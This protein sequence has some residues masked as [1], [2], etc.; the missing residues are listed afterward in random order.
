MT[1]IQKMHF[2]AVLALCLIPLTG[3]TQFQSVHVAGPATKLSSVT[4]FPS[5]NEQ[6]MKLRMTGDEMVPLPGMLFSVKQM[7]IEKFNVDGK[8]EAVV[9]APECTYAQLD[10]LASSSGHLDAKI[11]DRIH[12][13]GDGFLY[14]QSDNSLVISNNVYTVIKAGTRTLP[15]P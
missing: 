14:R 8:L 7:T 10:G 4:Y 1:C 15:I 13:Q 12:I 5:P 11:G 6:Q 2:V 3:R 9:Q